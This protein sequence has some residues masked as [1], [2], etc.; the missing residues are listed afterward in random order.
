VKFGIYDLGILL[1]TR[2]MYSL[3]LVNHLLQVRPENIVDGEPG[4][5][6]QNL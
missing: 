4:G 3:T 5:L 1:Q 6:G 2:V